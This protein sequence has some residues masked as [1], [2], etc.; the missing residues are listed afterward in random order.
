[1][2]EEINNHD[3]ETKMLLKKGLQNIPSNDFTDRLM[4]QILSQKKLRIKSSL[5]LK[6]SWIFVGLALI[7]LP[8]LIFFIANN[9]GIIFP[10]FTDINDPS[11]KFVLPLIILIIVSIILFQIENLM[12]LTI[13]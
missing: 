10:Y 2:N 4:K 3:I 12:K 8:I 6:I 5:N 11:M 13:N 7:I 1:M 9:F